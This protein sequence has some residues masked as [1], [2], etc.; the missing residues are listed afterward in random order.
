MSMNI[1]VQATN[2][3]LTDAIRDY[4]EKKLASVEE[5]LIERPD[6]LAQVEVGKTSAHHATGDIFRAE[7]VLELHDGKPKVVAVAERDDLFAAIDGMKDTLERE[8][9][10][11]KNKSRT[12]WR[13]GAGIVKD[14]LRES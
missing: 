14:L 8:L 6:A 9:V 3:D 11:R 12:L 13:K 5:K 7:T 10:E 4:I 2:I 1:S